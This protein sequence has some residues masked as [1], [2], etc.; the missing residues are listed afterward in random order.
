MPS[1][2]VAANGSGHSAGRNGLEEVSL[3][4]Q[5]FCDPPGK[6]KVTATQGIRDNT[7]L[8]RI[9]EQ[10]TIRDRPVNAPSTGICIATL[11]GFGLSA[12]VRTHDP[13][14]PATTIAAATG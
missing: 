5:V 7:G 14:G 9:P 12:T 11:S 3:H 10:G 8:S 2:I 13:H 4:C 1:S 6:G